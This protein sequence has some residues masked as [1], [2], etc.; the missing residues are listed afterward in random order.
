MNINDIINNKDPNQPLVTNLFKRI[1]RDILSG[2]LEAGDKI[3]EQK[4]CD[5]Y[6]VSRT[7][8]REA[9][10]H[11]EAEGLTCNVPNR[12]SF[13]VGISNSDAEDMVSLR[14]LLEIQCVKWAIE[15]IDEEELNLMK[16]IFDFM[17]Y[18]TAK[19]DIS[20][21]LNI[22]GAFHRTIYKASKNKMLSQNLTTYQ[23][24]LSYLKPPNV[25]APNYLNQVL[26]E[27]RAIYEAF[28]AEDIEGGA[29]A[30]DEH[31]RNSLLRK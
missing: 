27:H 15:R 25:Y 16:E 22:N 17:V 20:R 24:Y 13:V 2:K 5:E 19:N 31:M 11:L 3:T 14:H 12:G 28:L 30:M 23:T 18:Y 21:M 4:I 8:V 1:Q 10:R 26:S 29:L 6:K 9:L 7:P